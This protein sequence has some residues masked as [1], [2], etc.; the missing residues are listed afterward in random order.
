MTERIYVGVDPGGSFTGVCARQGE[1]RCGGHVLIERDGDMAV[2]ADEVAVEVHWLLNSYGSRGYECAVAIEDVNDPVPHMGLS[3]VRGLLDTSYLIGF[4]RASLDGTDVVMVPPGRHGSAPLGSYP[5]QLVGAREKR[6]AGRM[7]HVRSA[8]DV[9]G[10]ARL[11]AR[12]E[13]A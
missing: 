10:A 12:Q 6:G 3:N 2:Y 7:R 1:L 11:L 4:L 9:A 8:W 13:A 5:A